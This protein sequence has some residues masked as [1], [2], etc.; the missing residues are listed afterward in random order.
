MTKLIL[1]SAITAAVFTSACGTVPRS[2]GVMQLGPDTYRV[3]ARASLADVT[4]SQK[5]AFTEA[6]QF[7]GTLKKELLVIATDRI[8]ATGG[9][10]Y[11]I[12]FRCLMENDPAL[13]RPTLERAPDT[14]I[15]IK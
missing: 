14:V 4:E 13:I 5:M 9:G 6:K 15:Q 2:S 11:E 8:E 7:C 3:S 12:T 10:P 1:A